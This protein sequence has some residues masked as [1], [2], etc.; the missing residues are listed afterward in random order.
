MVS[1]LLRLP[2]RQIFACGKR[3]KFAAPLSNRDGWSCFSRERV[4]RSAYPYIKELDNSLERQAA[5]TFLST[6]L[7]KG[8]HKVSINSTTPG[9]RVAY[10]TGY[11]R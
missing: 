6:H 4:R 5:L 9:V 1:I 7:S 10:P 8:F 2:L 3:P 11:V